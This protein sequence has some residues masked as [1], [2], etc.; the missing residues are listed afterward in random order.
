MEMQLLFLE[1]GEEKKESK[2][3]CVYV[4]ESVFVYFT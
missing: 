1:G 3:V 4:Y 2:K